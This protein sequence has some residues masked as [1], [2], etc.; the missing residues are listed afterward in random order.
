M[1][2]TVYAMFA[3][4]SSN[5]YTR[6]ALES[7]FKSTRLTRSDDFYLI[8]NDNEGIYDYPT[9]K[10][11]SN[12]APKSFAR[13][14]NDIIELAAGRD[15]IILS[16]DVVFTPGWAEPLSHYSNVLLLPCCNQTHIYSNGL[17]NLQNSM[18][19]SEYNNQYELLAQISQSHKLQNKP[20][21]F[22][23]LVM[24]FF[25]FKLPAAVYKKV[26]MFDERFGV[27]GG[28]DVDYRLRAIQQNIPV[29]YQT[30][31]YLLHFGGKSTWDGP[32]QGKETLERDQKYTNAFIE[33]WG[34]DITTL[35]L[36][37]GNVMPIVEQ[38]NLANLIQS[39]DFSKAF[40][41]LL[42]KQS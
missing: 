23:R 20:G 30:Q 15:I 41:I 5:F 29:K 37:R 14:V 13:N 28:E 39:S 1:K 7:F 11:I 6:I 38:Y 3:S 36:G 10:I 12:I 17:L 27:G 24:G 32:E 31:S 35:S 19:L 22:E 4:K 2:G 9:L 42:N 25:V 40:K 26:G 21:F 8:D 18:T 34:V 16:N 33:K